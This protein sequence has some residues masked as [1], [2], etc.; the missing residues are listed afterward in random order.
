M[1][2]YAGL[3]ILFALMGAPAYAQNT[4][5]GNLARDFAEEQNAC[6]ADAWRF[7]GGNTIF[8]FEMENCLKRRLNSLSRPCRNLLSPTDFRKYHRERR[9]FGL[10]D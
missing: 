7:C 5:A 2:K 1:L 9:Y 4:W 10:F 6:Y 3:V 8:I